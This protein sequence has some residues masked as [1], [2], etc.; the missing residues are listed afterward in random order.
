MM[1]ILTLL[2]A[3]LSARPA[4]AERFELVGSAGPTLID[5][6]YSVAAGAGLRL[7]AALTFV[8]DVERTS[9]STQTSTSPTGSSSFRGGT[10]V[11]GSAGLRVAPFDRGPI[12]P[13][14]VIGLAAGVSRPNVNEIFTD[15]VTN[16]LRGIFGGGGVVVPFG[17]RL[18]VVADVRMLIG[19]ERGDIVA[20]A[21]LRV[22][23]RARF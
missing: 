17:P 18:A 20:V 4:R 11:L 6:G 10:L 7:N 22:G 19:V 16:G 23:I 9:L 15:R 1:S 21:P 13:L 8:A 2:M 5:A 14:A 3:L 12:R